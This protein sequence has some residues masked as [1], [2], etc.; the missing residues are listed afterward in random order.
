MYS[1]LIANR[2]DVIP[3][4]IAGAVAA[5]VQPGFLPA[6]GFR[7]AVTSLLRILRPCQKRPAIFAA[8]MGESATR[9]GEARQPARAATAPDDV[10]R[11]KDSAT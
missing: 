4:G 10:S 9:S 6:A 5:Y 3:D 2:L 11:P 7:R 1:K 8:G